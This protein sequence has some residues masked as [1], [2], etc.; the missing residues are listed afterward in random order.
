MST[1]LL[2]SAHVIYSYNYPPSF[3][4]SP[5]LNPSPNPRNVPTYSLR[6]HVKRLALCSRKS[7]IQTTSSEPIYRW[8]C[9]HLMARKL[10]RT[11]LTFYHRCKSYGKI[12]N[13]LCFF[14]IWLGGGEGEVTKIL[15]AKSCH[16]SCTSLSLGKSFGPTITLFLL[17]FYWPYNMEDLW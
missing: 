9:Y 12:N 1:L 14:F 15:C 13:F 7:G 16:L 4:L 8:P 2:R 5:A 17:L 6:S 11:L 3:G 10:E